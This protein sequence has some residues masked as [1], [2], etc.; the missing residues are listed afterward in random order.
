L[1]TLFCHILLKPQDPK[2]FEDLRIFTE[3]ST[4]ITKIP[5]TR[6]SLDEMAHITLI[7]DFITELGR[8]AEC[9]IVKAKRESSE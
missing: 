5:K 6:V 4:A 3:A 9:A 2:A 7:E 1:L 8:L